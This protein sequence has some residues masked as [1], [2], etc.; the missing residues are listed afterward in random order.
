MNSENQTPE[1]APPDLT[2]H[3]AGSFDPNLLGGAPA[4]AV[5]RFFL[6]RAGCGPTSLDTDG[7]ED[8]GLSDPRPG[9]MRVPDTFPPA[10]YAGP[11]QTVAD[12]L[13]CV[14]ACKFVPPVAPPPEQAPQAS[15][16][17]PGP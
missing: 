10:G 12:L 15:P 6:G 7:L 5:K 16:E 8:L 4:D 3:A 13:S 2:K 1:A 9:V 17:P 14:D 11:L